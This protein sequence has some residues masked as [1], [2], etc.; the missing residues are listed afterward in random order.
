MTPE[1]VEEHGLITQPVTATDRRARKFIERFGTQTAELDAIPAS[2]IR[3]LTKTAIERHIDPWR[4]EQMRMVEQQ[5]RE[6]L[7]RFL[8]GGGESE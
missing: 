4:V 8:S 2:K 5:E 6:G 1:Q 7:N 3:A